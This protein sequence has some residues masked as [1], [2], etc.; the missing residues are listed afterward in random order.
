MKT[1]FLLFFTISVCLSQSYDNNFTNATM[2]VD[3]Y[4]IGTK[5]QEQITL[6][7]VYEE[8]TW[9][10]SKVNLLDTLNL[11]DC[12]VKVSDLQTNLL[13]Y[14][15]GY[16]TVFGE[17]QTTEEAISGT[18]RTFQETVRFPFPKRKVIVSFNRR[19][20]FVGAGEVMAFRE[21]FSTVINPNNSTVV[22]REKQESKFAMFDVMVNGP[23]DK[24]VDIL[25][26]GDGYAKNDMEKFRKDARHF[27]DQLFSYQP[28]KKHKNDFNVRAME[29][30][31]DDS[32]IDMPDQN[33]WKHTALGTMYNTFGS[34]RY[35]LTEENRA[36]RD[37][38]D[39]AP[40]DFIT[41][42][43][44][45]NRYGGGGIFNLYTTCFTK[46]AKAGQEWEMDYVYVHE[47][48]HCFGGLGDEY[49]SSQVSY[50]DFYPKGVEP[51][52]PNVT[53]TNSKEN[54]KWRNITLLN[55]PIP[56]PWQKAKYDS[57]EILRG[58]LDRL[59]SDYYDKREGLLKSG[60]E[61]LKDP[62]WIG[63][64]GAFEGSGYTSKDMYRPAIDCK[65]FTFNPVDFDPVCAAAIERIIEMYIK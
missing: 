49:Y 27:T 37:I 39:T 6:D 34:A 21:V 18:W 25:I 65:M 5:G 48:G 56:T 2:R 1:L 26:L 9:P 11:G 14:S 51:W 44:N 8:N 20:K 60:K 38:A 3:Y 19:D 32:G 58:K 40:Y 63:I 4:H 62:K 42:L 12:F 64:V 31:S 59:A 16:S 61:I 23:T 24:K 41:I 46:P 54:L 22:N 36:M 43:V 7:K 17:W 30:I 28:F 10:G 13:L 35:V 15:R 52:E 45:D 33:V 29:V 53:R 55:T 57:I 50:V 47:F